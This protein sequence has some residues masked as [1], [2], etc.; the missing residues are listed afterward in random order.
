VSDAEPAKRWKVELGASFDPERIGSVGA[1]SITFVSS[2]SYAESIGTTLDPLTFDDEVWQV[3]QGLS[4]E[5]ADFAHNTTTFTIH[6]VGDVAINPREYAL[7]ITY[8]GASDGLA[9]TNTTTGDSWSYTGTSAIG[10]A[11]V[12]DGIEAKKNE[13]SIVPDTNLALI[14]L[15]DGANDFELAGTDGSFEITFDFRFRTL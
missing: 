7:V 3:G 13:S 11:I 6:N 15:A 9:I 5:P 2:S 1:F 4:L 10:D 8:T 14:T 12:L